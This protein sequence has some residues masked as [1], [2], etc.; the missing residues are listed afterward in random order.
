MP[1]AVRYQNDE[2]RVV[3]FDAVFGRMRNGADQGDYPVAYSR[4]TRRQINAVVKKEAG[5][6][7]YELV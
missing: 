5:R 2:L 6:R 4:L 1:Q 7:G 3:G